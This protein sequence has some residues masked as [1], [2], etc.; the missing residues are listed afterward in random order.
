MFSVIINLDIIWNLRVYS[1]QDNK[2]NVDEPYNM[3]VTT[4]FLVGNCFDLT[5]DA[6]NPIIAFTHIETEFKL[7][8]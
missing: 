2:N 3:P 4:Q 8:A 5:Y 7:W 6:G 1:K